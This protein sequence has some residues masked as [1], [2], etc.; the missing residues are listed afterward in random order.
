M[1]SAD[2]DGPLN[3]TEPQ[4]DE[5]AVDGPYQYRLQA[6]F[7]KSMLAP[8][9]GN[10]KLIAMLRTR[11]LTTAVM[12]EVLARPWVRQVLGKATGR[13]EEAIVEL[14]SNAYVR[15]DFFVKIVE[16]QPVRPYYHKLSPELV[17]LTAFEPDWPSLAFDEAALQAQCGPWKAIRRGLSENAFK[18]A[19]LSTLCVFMIWLKV[20]AALESWDTLE[21]GARESTVHAAFALSSL[22]TV[23]W[24]IRTAIEIVPDLEEDLGHLRAAEPE[25]NPETGT[26]PMK[27]PSE[28]RA[29]GSAGSVP[30]TDVALAWAC[31]G[32]ELIRLHGE[33]EQTPRRGPLERLIALGNRAAEMVGTV[34][35]D[36]KP[37]Q[38]MLQEGLEALQLRLLD[39][40]RDAALSWLGPDVIAQVTARWDIK[41]ANAA[42]EQALVDLADDAGRALSRIAAAC[43]EMQVAESR[44]IE[45]KQASEALESELATRTSAIRK[46]ELVER[47]L[48]AREDSINAERKRSDVML[49]VLASAS[50]YGE[51]FDPAVDYTAKADQQSPAESNPE[52]VS[53]KPAV[54][55]DTHA[56]EG[57]AAP[58]APAQSAEARILDDAG[59]A[60][61]QAPEPPA[62]VV[63]ALVPAASAIAPV[64]VPKPVV[65]VP[66]D[67]VTEPLR[68]PIALHALPATVVGVAT[69]TPRE[70]AADSPDIQ[71]A[72]EF[73]DAAGDRCRPIWSLLQQGK[74]ALA[75][76]FAAAL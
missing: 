16:R 25:G 33:W 63:D 71:S 26:S 34:P 61:A 74:P 66:R 72:Q 2:D 48:Q 32:D 51:V 54:E 41:R 8:T 17:I 23:D 76:Q 11:G 18:D 59:T 4:P 27:V 40:A 43:T 68:A 15:T 19:K 28:P 60:S 9:P 73:S 46:L 45:A 30:S 57:S 64:L 10:G 38:A 1:N 55:P 35:E 29:V 13:R 50:P 6:G 39:V 42:D 53:G 12:K 20:R 58:E 14:L 56:V 7:P 3:A 31:I 36:K 44:V 24:F 69:S 47:S 75:F 62:T 67:P 65:Q 49:F 21:A 70:R 22:G 52:M 37:P 5:T